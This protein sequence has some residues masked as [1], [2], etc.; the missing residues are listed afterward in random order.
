MRPKVDR[1]PN[2]FIAHYLD[3]EQKRSKACHWKAIMESQQG[4]V[5]KPSEE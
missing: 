4:V 3:A 1:S 5:K 2:D